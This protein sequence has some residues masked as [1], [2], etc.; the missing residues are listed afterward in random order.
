MI[1]RERFTDP[2]VETSLV[3]YEKVCEGTFMDT[4]RGYIEEIAGV[5]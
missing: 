2:V 1:K 3:I 5:C 4:T